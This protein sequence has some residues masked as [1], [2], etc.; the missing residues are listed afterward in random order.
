MKQINSWILAP[1]VL[2]VTILC[3][4]GFSFWIAGCAS[5]IR[6]EIDTTTTVTT[7]TYKGPSA[8]TTTSSSSTTSKPGIPPTTTTTTVPV[9]VWIEQTPSAAFSSREG[10]TSL[11][12]NGKLWVIAGGTSMVPYKNDV[13]YSTDGT[14]WFLSTAEAAFT[15]RK[16]SASVVFNSRLWVIGGYTHTGSG[17]DG[18]DVWSSSDGVT[19][20][21][22]TAEAGFSGRS[23]HAAIVFN[24]RIWLIGGASFESGG[25]NYRLNDV[26]SSPD[27]VSWTR[28]VAAAPFGP[29]AEHTCLVYDNKIWVI[30][31]FAGALFLHDVWS[32]SDGKNWN[33]ATN[34]AAFSGRGGHASVIYNNKMWVI[35]GDAG[36]TPFQN[37]A[38]SSLDGM[39][40]TQEA[41]PGFSG[42]RYL[43]GVVS[44]KIRIIGGYSYSEKN[45]VWLSP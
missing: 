14:N 11:V 20:E 7:S 45:D 31:G 12:N 28:E 23:G 13:W 22:A 26:W 6:G 35:G 30:G 40:W 38:W 33:A 16:Y 25:F 24:N 4:W 37:D 1:A 19:W 8:S 18:N 17:R 34:S 21:L 27:G 5:T 36:S 10:H 42:R 43:T 39:L 29:R 3:A 2:A 41:Y 15:G 9:A 32:S 44:D